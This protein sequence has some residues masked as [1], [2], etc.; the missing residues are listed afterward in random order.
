[1]DTL[2]LN[3]R[4]RHLEELA[5]EHLQLYRGILQV[6]AT[7]IRERH[8]GSLEESLRRGAE[9][10]AVLASLHSVLQG[11]PG[12]PTGAAGGHGE[13][14]REIRTLHAEV[15]E[16]QRTNRE[17]LRSGMADMQETLASMETPPRGPGS[18]FAPPAHGGNMVDVSV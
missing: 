16:L 12:A 18:V 7:A 11:M 6:Q 4:R 15:R 3:H 2:R 10:L 17:A 13:L 14:H 8:L 1:M 9:E 5:L